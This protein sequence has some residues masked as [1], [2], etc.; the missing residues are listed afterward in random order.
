MFLFFKLQPGFISVILLS[1]QIEGA[2]YAWSASEIS[3]ALEAAG[4]ADGRE[5]A[6]VA[7]QLAVFKAR[8]GVTETGN[9]RPASNP[10]GELN[11]LNVL[12][13]AQTIEGRH[14]LGGSVVV[15][16]V[17]KVVCLLDVL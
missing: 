13:V 16:V 5:P 10:L 15:C 14:S 3:D 8:Y 12:Y 9:T 6:W 1:L 2:Y 7:Q 17:R 11:G 4:A